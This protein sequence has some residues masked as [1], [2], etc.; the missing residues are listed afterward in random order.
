MLPAGPSDV[1]HAVLDTN[2]LVSALIRPAGPPGLVMA[3]VL[4][5]DLVPVF[6][7]EIVAEYERVLRRPRLR[8]DTIKVQA[9]LDTMRLVG[10]RLVIESV[11]PP[12]DLPDRDDWPFITCGVAAGCPV[13]T[14][15]AKHFPQM[16]GLRVMTARQWMDQGAV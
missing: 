2:I 8:L 7:E 16:R 6:S 5:G 14:G 9:M 1:Q 3:A 4:R 10:V 12:S 15:N 11:P 13:V